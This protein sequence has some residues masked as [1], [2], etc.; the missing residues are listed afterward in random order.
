MNIKHIA[1]PAAALLLSSCLSLPEKVTLSMD[2]I[3]AMD[4]GSY[5][6]NYEALAK[7]H[8]AQVLLD[9][10]SARYGTFSRPRKFL[11]VSERWGA[12]AG[13]YDFTYHTSY[14]SCV[15][16][17][18][19]NT[20]GGYTGWQT[21][22]VKFKNGSVV[23]SRPDVIFCNREGDVVVEAPAFGLEIVGQ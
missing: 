9:P 21:H 11:T 15:N 3:R 23:L 17:N 19:K 7:R 8:F 6:H 1:L 12:R 14:F 16:I 20:Y 22:L 2:E 4:Y 18:A 13:T 5:P 10:D